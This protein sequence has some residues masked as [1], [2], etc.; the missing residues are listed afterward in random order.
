MNCFSLKL[1][2][3]EKFEKY[4]YNKELSFY[5]E[6]R[7]LHRK[8]LDMVCDE[9]LKSD[10]DQFGPGEEYGLLRKLIKKPSTV[11]LYETV[12]NKIFHIP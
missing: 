7:V 4:G 6:Q 3:P 9:R 10:M 2:F 8:D 12:E 5:R 11:T 1:L